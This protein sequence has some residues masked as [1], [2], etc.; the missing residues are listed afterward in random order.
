LSR[1]TVA[2]AVQTRVMATPASWI[3]SCC[4]LP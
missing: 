3:R 1:T 4:G 2:K